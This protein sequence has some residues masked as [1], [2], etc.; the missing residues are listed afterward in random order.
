[1]AGTRETPISPAPGF[2]LQLVLPEPVEPVRGKLGVP[3]RVLSVRDQRLYAVAE[4]QAREE[5]LGLWR[6]NSP[7]PP[8]E[9]RRLY[10]E[11]YQ[12][13]AF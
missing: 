6:E 9:H 5:S 3:D 1:M 11:S 2:F 4:N 7:N 10:S 8:W 12:S 13:D